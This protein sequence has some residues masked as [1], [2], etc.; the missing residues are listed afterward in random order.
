MFGPT[1]GVPIGRSRGLPRPPSGQD[2]R[3]DAVVTLEDQV[4]EVG[5]R[6]RTQGRQLGRRLPLIEHVERP[7]ADGTSL[8]MRV[9]RSGAVIGADDDRADPGGPL[10][11]PRQSPYRLDVTTA[12]SYA[13][14]GHLAGAEQQVCVYLLEWLPC[15]RIEQWDGRRKQAFLVPPGTGAAMRAVSQIS[16]MAQEFRGVLRARAFHVVFLPVWGSCGWPQ[17]S[18]FAKGPAGT[19]WPGEPRVPGRRLRH[20]TGVFA[21]LC[22]NSSSTRSTSSKLLPPS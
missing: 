4:V 18:E 12:S 19:R 17:A 16:E 21:C 1:G 7:V 6:D 20:D 14:R 3:D 22:R 13:C 2:G 15:V 10:L 8:K 9:V 5:R 11:G